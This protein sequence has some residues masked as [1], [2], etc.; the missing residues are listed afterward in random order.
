MKHQFSYDVKRFDL[1]LRV[2][3]SEMIQNTVTE[4]NLINKRV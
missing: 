4:L 1:I 2:E 3:E